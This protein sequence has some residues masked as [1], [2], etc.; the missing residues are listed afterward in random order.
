[1]QV[2]Q[3]HMLLMCCCSQA[4]CF[5]CD[6]G[7]APVSYH[8]TF[9]PS[10]PSNILQ[11]SYLTSFSSVSDAVLVI[12]LQ[13]FALANVGDRYDFRVTGSIIFPVSISAHI[14]QPIS[15]TSTNA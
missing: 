15:V 13:M 7:E 11:S 6:E 2:L 8:W 3:Y 14:L 10:N 9:E 5:N 1:M 12:D 4:L